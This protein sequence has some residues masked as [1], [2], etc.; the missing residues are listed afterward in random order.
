MRIRDRNFVFRECNPE[1]G[2]HPASFLRRPVADENEFPVASAKS[3]E[4]TRLNG[5]SWAPALAL[6]NSLPTEYAAGESG[7]PIWL[8]YPMV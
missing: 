8:G 3:N 2:H 4:R 5:R 7:R 6:M 1:A